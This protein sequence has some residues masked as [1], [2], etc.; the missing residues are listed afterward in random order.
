MASVTRIAITRSLLSASAS[1]PP[2][3]SLSSFLSPS[4]LRLPSTLPPLSLSLSFS[5]LPLPKHRRIPPALSAADDDDAE[6]G[7]TDYD[8]DEEDVEELDNKKD[9]DIEYDK[10]LGVA[11]VSSSADSPDD[12][13]MVAV[14]SFVSTQGWESETVVDYRINEEEFHKIRLFHCD[15]FI[16]KPPDP[17]D[18]VYDFREM[19]VTPP[20][21]DVYSIPKVLAPMPQKYIRCAKSNF[22]SYNV[23][24]PPI[25]APRDPLY[26]TEREIMKVFLTKHYRNRRLRDS[27]FVLDFEEIYVIDSK[28]KSITRAKVLVSVPGGRNRDRRKDL[29]IIRDGGNSFKIIDKS[30]RDDPTAVIEREEW[31]KTR[32]EMENHL[33]KL[34]DFHVSNWF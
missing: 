18:N 3:S 13:E 9:Y 29:L 11:P 16:R 25:D 15:F 23:T 32:Q 17:D 28:T 6:A 14:E 5:S 24:E 34:R 4:S 20:D 12:I 1:E 26:K 21:T 8:M 30:E 33:R 2:S 27:E 22:G 31:S 19:Y 7:A 10:I